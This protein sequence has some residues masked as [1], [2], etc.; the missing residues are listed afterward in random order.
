MEFVRSIGRWA[1]AGLVINCIIGSGIFGIPGELTRRLGRASPLAMIAAGLAM[2]TIMACYAEVASQ[3]TEPGGSYL[4]VRTAFGRFAGMQAGWFW[5]L[6]LLGGCAAN[7]NLLVTYLAGMFPQTAHGWTRAAILTA[8]IAIPVAA[9]YR[10]V[11]AGANVSSVLT[12][13]KLA[14]LG[15]LIALGLWRFGHAAQTIHP[16]E[17][18]TPGWKAWAES[19]LLV[20]F[21]YEGYEDTV[22]PSGEVKNPRK[23]IP[24]ALFTGMA[25]CMA[26]YAL[27]QFVTV[28]TIGNQATDRPIGAVAAVLLGP[29][30]E[31]FVAIAVMLSVY[32]YISAAILNA[33]RLASAF[34]ENGDGPEWLGRLHPRF[35]TP[36]LAIFLF[37]AL[38][39][40]LALTGTFLWALALAV[41][42]STIY[43]G[44]VCASL[45]RLRRMRPNAE[46]L[47]IR[48]GPVWAVL[49]II[50][51]P[52]MLTQMDVREALL[53]L[54]TAGLAAANWWWARQRG[55]GAGATPSCQIKDSA[56]GAVR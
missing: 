42:A 28:A 17:I 1:L 47:R 54:V 26:V 41:G 32:G 8:V 16:A 35:R 9:N 24:F 33:P 37:A 39:W 44:G 34:A 40:I 50:F 49:G 52:L 23:S 13:A 18:I 20:I 15:I 2:A 27:L 22:V 7:A 51:S 19:L 53:M 31:T 56:T 36:G 14:P 12:V 6:S 30:G 25:V 38:V 10:G 5:L 55:A 43:Y 11:R 46:A 29:G 3:F 48:W 21:A 45:I 4:Y